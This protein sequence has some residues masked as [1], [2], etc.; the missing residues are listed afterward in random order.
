MVAAARR[1]EAR[2]GEARRGEARRGEAKQSG[3]GKQRPQG[4]VGGKH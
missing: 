2:R 4:K 3:T 1:G